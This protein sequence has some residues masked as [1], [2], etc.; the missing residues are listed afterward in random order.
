MLGQLKARVPGAFGEKLRAIRQVKQI[1]GAV[2]EPQKPTATL[3]DAPVFQTTPGACSTCSTTRHWR[4]LTVA[5]P[6]V[7]G[8]HPPGDSTLVAVWEDIGRPEKITIDTERDNARDSS[9]S[10]CGQHTHI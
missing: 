2:I 4:T 5:L 3:G 10:V 6:S 1:F 7:A 8:A 9:L